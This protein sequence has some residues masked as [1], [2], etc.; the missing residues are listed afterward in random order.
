LVRNPPGQLTGQELHFAGGLRH[1][2]S[3]HSLLRCLVEQGPEGVQLGAEGGQ[4]VA[5][6]LLVEQAATEYWPL[7]G[8]FHGTG[9]DSLQG[10]NGCEK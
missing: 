9:N 10:A 1:I 6:R 3:V 4:P 7:E 5:D 2:G 8:K